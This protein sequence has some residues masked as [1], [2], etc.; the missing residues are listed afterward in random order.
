MMN[1]SYYEM[2]IEEYKE[3]IKMLED[4]GPFLLSGEDKN[5]CVK[6]WDMYT[7]FFCLDL[8]AH[9]DWNGREHRAFVNNA[10]PP[11]TAE[12]SAQEYQQMFNDKSVEDFDRLLYSD[13][14]ITKKLLNYD[15]KNGTDLF[16]KFISYYSS[17]ALIFGEQS[18]KLSNLTEDFAKDY[19][20]NANVYKTSGGTAWGQRKELASIPMDN[21]TYIQNTTLDIMNKVSQNNASVSENN[22][23][24]GQISQ[25]TKSKVKPTVD[26][27][28]CIRV[29]VPFIAG[30]GLLWAG[31]A[32]S[33][34]WMIIGGAI[35]A[36]AFIF[37]LVANRK[38]CPQCRAWNPWITTS[39]Q[40]VGQKKVKVRR[41]LN[42]TYYRTSGRA[43]FGTRQVFVNADEYT[44]KETYRCSHCGYELVGKRTVIDDG[45]R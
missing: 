17:L 32:G 26:G 44:Y 10:I 35:G 12:I 11:G 3:I 23:S 14:Y 20:S 5:D 33:S 30:V 28:F 36:V 15:R 8:I 34:L 19:S 4:L 38:R 29:I 13:H 9:V 16:S 21:R 37:G 31:I 18:V 6:S 25:Y 7:K 45:I 27:Q 39:S 41:N 1:D 43:T 42:S 2:L 40:Q 22:T 24:S